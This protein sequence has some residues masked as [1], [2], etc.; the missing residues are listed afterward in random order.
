[1][2]LPLLPWLLLLLIDATATAAVWQDFVWLALRPNYRHDLINYAW[3]QHAADSLS[4]I[5]YTIYAVHY[6]AETTS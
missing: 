5:L 4:K 6:V 1:M 2:M 3:T